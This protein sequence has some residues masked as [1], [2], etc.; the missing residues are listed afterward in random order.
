[1]G[2]W[3]EHCRPLDRNARARIMALAEGLERRSKV[4]GRRNGQLGLTG[5][6]VLRALLMR[7]L[8]RGTGLCYPSYEA[9]R[10]ETGLC[11]AAIAHA[12]ARL[13]RTGIVRIVRR[14]C[15]QWVERV[16]P[17]TGQ[18]ERYLGTTQTSS[19]YALHEPGAWADH[20]PLPTGRRAPFPA[21]RQL[22]LLERGALTWSCNGKLSLASREEPP[23]T[24][25]PRGVHSL[26]MA[27]E[28][29][30][31][32]VERANARRFAVSGAPL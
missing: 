21:P 15:R 27:I 25:T 19:L 23:P 1:V 9:I 12:I 11:R 18:P 10:Q 31:A 2:D 29:L 32:S 26:E 30:R 16:N 8:N 6:A 22:A 3:R 4:A 28:A 17:V 7:F 14:L 20:L 24:S 13:E 5:L